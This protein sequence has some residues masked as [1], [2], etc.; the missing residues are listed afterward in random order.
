MGNTPSASQVF[1]PVTSIANNI[2]NG[3]QNAIN[4]INNS[5]SN[6]IS[7]KTLGEKTL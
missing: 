6:I 1:Q 2:G 3:A 7:Q 4:E 5:G